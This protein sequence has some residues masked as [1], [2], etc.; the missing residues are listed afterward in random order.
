MRI[1]VCTESTTDPMCTR[2]YK[3][4]V[5]RIRRRKEMPVEP[6]QQ[7]TAHPSRSAFP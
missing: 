3:R 1:E 2:L 7:I 4:E 6:A 5:M